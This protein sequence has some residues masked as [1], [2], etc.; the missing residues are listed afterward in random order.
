MKRNK[1]QR[2]APLLI[3]GPNVSSTFVNKRPNRRKIIQALFS[4]VN[5]KGG[6]DVPPTNCLTKVIMQ[7]GMGHTHAH[8]GT[9]VQG[10]CLHM[11]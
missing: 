4:E 1:G 6:A 9:H 8:A 3:T 10:T 7:S 11:L 2:D 5:R